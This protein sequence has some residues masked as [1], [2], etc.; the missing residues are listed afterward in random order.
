MPVKYLTLAPAALVAAALSVGSC[1]TQAAEPATALINSPATKFP[2]RYAWWLT[3]VSKGDPY[4]RCDYTTRSCLMGMMYSNLFAG[5]VIAAED[6]KTVL[7]HIMCLGGTCNDFDSGISGY[8][9]NNPQP[10]QMDISTECVEMAKRG[11]LCA[12][13]QNGRPSWARP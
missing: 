6:R 11:Q 1:P 3:Q 5:V 10:Y 8:N 9:T 2:N 12:M 7:A 13:V 4:F